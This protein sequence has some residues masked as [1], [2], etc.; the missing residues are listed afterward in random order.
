MSD[1]SPRVHAETSAQWRDW[2][3]AQHDVETGVWLVSWKKATGRPAIGYAESVVEALA[4]G[5]VDSKGG[6]VDAER[7]ML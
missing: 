1:D 2:L 5:W 3:A 7:T 4:W 6:K